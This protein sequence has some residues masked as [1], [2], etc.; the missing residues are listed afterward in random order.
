MLKSYVDFNNCEEGDAI[1]VRLDTELNAGISEDQMKAGSRVLLYDEELECEAIL[2]HDDD[3]RWVAD[4]QRDTI[5]H[6]P[7]DQWDRLKKKN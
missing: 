6:L 7:P 4:L 3:H 5:R 1:I 2:R